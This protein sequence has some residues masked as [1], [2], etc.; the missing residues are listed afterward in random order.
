MLCK[1]C[2]CTN[3]VWYVYLLCIMNTVVAKYDVGV[4]VSAFAEL[5]TC[6]IWRLENIYTICPSMQAAQ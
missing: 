3:V 6:K 2:G 5:I 1:T 4:I